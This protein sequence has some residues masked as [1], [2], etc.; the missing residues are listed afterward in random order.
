[1]NKEIFESALAAYRMKDYE[2]AIILFD[3]VA[4]PGEPCGE[5]YHHKGNAL[6]QLGRFLEA[7]QAYAEALR[8]SSYAKRGAV[9]TNKGR[10][11]LSLYQVDSAINSF[12]MALEDPSYTARYKAFTALG[13]AY[14]QKG[15]TKSAGTAF[16]NAALDQ[17]NPDPSHALLQLGLCFMQLNRPQDAVEAYRTA[18]DFSMPTQQK[19]EIYEKL[20]QSYVAL[21]RMDEALSAFSQAQDTSEGHTHVLSPAAQQDYQRAFKTL[22]EK[23]ELLKRPQGST[24]NMLAPSASGSYPMDLISQS[25][26]IMPSPEE[27]GFFEITESDLVKISKSQKKA[28]RKHKHTGLKLMLVFLLIVAALIAFLV[29]AF[30]RGYGY[31]TQ[32]AVIKDMVNAYNAD[33]DVAQYWAVDNAATIKQEMRQIP[34][35]T[36]P[37]VVGIDRSTNESVVRIKAVLPEG[38]QIYY[39][40]KMV[41]DKAG[42]KMADLKL[43]FDT[44][45]DQK[46]FGSSDNANSSDASGSAGSSNSA[47]STTTPGSTGNEG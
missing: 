36:K 42:F 35:N 41:R 31:P 22:E 46:G 45:P 13:N 26:V 4:S 24:G 40:A 14:L 34:K 21:N 43:Y 32:T 7:S 29:I 15:E 17:S 25:G 2:Q 9:A 38:G 47:Q 30:F 39:L 8:D 16:R 33:K 1:M 28:E 44:L 18:L 12:H 6:M 3:Q 27:S 20:G 5:A 37:E 10:A 11:E 19:H 23:R